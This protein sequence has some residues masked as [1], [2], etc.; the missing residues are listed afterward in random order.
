[1]NQVMI[2]S[3]IAVLGFIFQMIILGMSVR[4]LK[5]AKMYYEQGRIKRKAAMTI[6]E[7][8]EIWR[9]PM[10]EDERA[11]LI[12]EWHEKLAAANV[13]IQMSNDEL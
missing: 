13:I 11:N 1:M 7:F 6:M 12:I 5:K 10:S 9:K 2:S 8:A 4:R 3:V